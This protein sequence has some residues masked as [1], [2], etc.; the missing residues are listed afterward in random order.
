LGTDEDVGVECSICGVR[1]FAPLKL[2]GMST[3]S[4]RCACCDWLHVA[5]SP[6]VLLKAI[7]Y[8]LTINLKAAKAL[9]L[10]VPPSMLARA[11]EV[12]E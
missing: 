7:K 9:G 4:S 5:H 8:E 3:S 10:S 11:D 2:S 6:A 12:I 1:I